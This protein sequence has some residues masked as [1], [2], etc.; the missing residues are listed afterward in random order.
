MAHLSVP[1]IATLIGEG[2][3]GGALALAV[4][5]RVLMQENATY[6]VITPEGCAAI[7]WRDAAFAPQAAEALRPTAS[8]LLALGVVEASSKSRAAAPTTTRRRPR[9]RWGRRSPPRWRS[10][11]SS[12]PRTPATAPRALPPPRGLDR[13]GRR[14]DGAVGDPRP[15]TVKRRA[16]AA[17]LLALA[18][19]AA[20]VTAA[21]GDAPQSDDAFA[22]AWQRVTG[23]VPDQD[24]T[25]T[26]TAKGG[27][28]ELTFA[29]RANGK[30]LTVDGLAEGDELLCTLPTGEGGAAAPKWAPALPAE[31]D[32]ALVAA[33]TGDRLAVSMVSRD[34]GRLPLW[35]YQRAAE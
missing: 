21:C 14:R 22:G 24:F 2:G 7:L 34:G 33:E 25:L 3:S 28:Y 5:D 16:A 20:L 4:A 26:V 29:N 23:G 13:A 8:Q 30:S 27:A 1:V 31:V 18:V 12:T 32:V 10:S 11:T 17:V 6:S 19:A 9:R 35:G 15:A